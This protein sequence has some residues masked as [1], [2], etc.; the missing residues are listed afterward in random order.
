MLQYLGNPNRSGWFAVRKP[1]APLHLTLRRAALPV[2]AALLAGGMAVAR[3]DAPR[4]KAPQAPAAAPVWTVDKAASRL[5]FRVATGDQSFDGV[6]KTWDAQLAFDPHNLKAS[7]AMVTITMASAVTGEPTRDQQLPGSDG[8]DVARFPKA[9]F[10]SSAVTAAGPGRYTATG[11]L[12]V[13]GVRRRI[14]LPFNL[15]ITKDTVKIDGAI[16]L[17]SGDFGLNSPPA[18]NAEVTVKVRLTAR[19]AH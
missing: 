10:E 9:T 15:S 14:E 8:F 3:A 11:D 19:K 13:H 12:T 17:Q 1:G 5:T 6:F 4:P 16:T 18:G 2:M 7:R